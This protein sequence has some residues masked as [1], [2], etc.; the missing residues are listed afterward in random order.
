MT[1]KQHIHTWRTRLLALFVCAQPGDPT[2]PK[3][4][5]RSTPRTVRESCLFSPPF[6]LP[7]PPGGFHLQWTRCRAEPRLL[8]P[9]SLRLRRWGEDGLVEGCRVVEGSC[10]TTLCA[11]TEGFQLAVAEHN[12]FQ[13]KV[14]EHS[15]DLSECSFVR[16]LLCAHARW[17]FSALVLE[18]KYMALL[19]WL[20]SAFEEGKHHG[21]AGHSHF[22][23]SCYGVYQ[24]IDLIHVPP[25][26]FDI[27]LRPYNRW[28]I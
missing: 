25:G 3:V 7:F 17:I 5:Y 16:Q 10:G 21:C 19:D 6:R 11:P 4:E 8:E 14:V 9:S 28:F 18:S 15:L 13:H 26:K 20:D 1:T 24:L 27:P 12:F 22:L 23:I 2:G